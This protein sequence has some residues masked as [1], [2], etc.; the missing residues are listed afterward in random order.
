MNQIAAIAIRAKT[1]R[2]TLFA[3][4]KHTNKIATHATRPTMALLQLRAV[5]DNTTTP[6]ATS[7]ARS[8]QSPRV[9]GKPS[10]SFSVVLI[11]CMLGEALILERLRKVWW[12]PAT[13]F[14]TEYPRRTRRRVP[15]IGSSLF[16]LLV[17]FTLCLGHHFYN[18]NGYTIE[19]LY[20]KDKRSR[21]SGVCSNHRCA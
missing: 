19:I 15:L 14:R 12:R 17:K 4:E 13:L 6:K 10:I 18:F 3:G 2:N 8:F 7:P 20:K 9:S 1:A 16:R 21:I 5:D 11:F